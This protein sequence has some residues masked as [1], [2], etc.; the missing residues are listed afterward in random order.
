MTSILETRG[1]AKSFGAIT[2]A[3]D[4]N[5]TINVPGKLHGQEFVALFRL[6]NCFLN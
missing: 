4:I 1:L 3:A 5:V 6:H 2:A